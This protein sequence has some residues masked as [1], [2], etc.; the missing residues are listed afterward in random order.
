ME[1]ILPMMDAP[2]FLTGLH[3]TNYLGSPRVSIIKKSGEDYGFLYLTRADLVRLLDLL[4]V[5]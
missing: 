2:D 4:G 5:E 3:L 1:V